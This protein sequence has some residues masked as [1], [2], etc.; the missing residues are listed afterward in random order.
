MT[1]IKKA[2][3][4]QKVR[5]FIQT[6]PNWLKAIVLFVFFALVAS[7][8]F[9]S[10][11]TQRQSVVRVSE[12]Q[13]NYLGETTTFEDIVFVGTTSSLET[14][15]SIYS[16]S[17]TN[18][19]EQIAQRLIERY[20]LLPS[21]HLDDLWVNGESSLSYDALSQ[22][23]L[24]I[25]G[26]STSENTQG[27]FN[28]AAAIQEAQQFLTN[29]LQIQ[30]ITPLQEGIIYF[31]S[32]YEFNKT[33]ELKAT[34]AQIP[35]AQTTVENNPVFQNTAYTPPYIV[36]IDKDN[37]LLKVVFSP[38][39]F[40]AR[41]EQEADLISVNTAIENINNNQGILIQTEH[42]PFEYT[43]LDSINSGSLDQ[44]S[45]EYRLDTDQSLI[46]P[47]YRFTGTLTNNQGQSFEGT[48]ITPAVETTHQP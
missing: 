20:A 30:N 28:T 31:D 36:V 40:S 32:G 19:G 41:A 33:S 48:I 2:T 25:P 5:H 9:Q 8:I 17:L 29:D 3:F 4:S 10:L 22:E 18:Q 39:M 14:T 12:G 26:L 47:F 15:G 7:S 21:P 45:V 34:I 27:V 35:F 44:A 16:T 24:F 23:F 1:N 38:Y 13:V 11:T 42:N 37:T 43:P 6:L 46:Y